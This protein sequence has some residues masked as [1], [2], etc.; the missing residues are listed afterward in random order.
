MNIGFGFG[1]PMEQVRVSARTSRIR[2]V[3]DAEPSVAA[4]GRIADGHISSRASA[5]LRDSR[6]VIAASA[7]EARPCRLATDVV[8]VSDDQVRHGYVYKR[9]ICRRWHSHVEAS[10]FGR[11]PTQ[12]APTCQ[13]VLRKHCCC[14]ERYFEAAASRD[15]TLMVRRQSPRI[16]MNALLAAMCWF[17]VDVI[18]SL[19]RE[20]A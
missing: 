8:F 19:R 5:A 10:A 12:T 13:P 9:G 3:S 17:G 14:W 20:V 6:I 7:G 4:A 11:S 2:L 15:V 16:D 1:I 18:P